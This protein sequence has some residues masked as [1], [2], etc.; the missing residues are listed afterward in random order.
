MFVRFVDNELFSW[1]LTI[2]DYISPYNNRHEHISDAIWLDSSSLFLFDFEVAEYQKESFMLIDIAENRIVN[3]VGFADTSQHGCDIYNSYLVDKFKRVFF[4][5]KL[6][7]KG[8]G[9]SSKLYFLNLAKTD[10][11]ENEEERSAIQLLFEESSEILFMV[12]NT[13]IE[14]G[15]HFGCISNCARKHSNF[16]S[17]E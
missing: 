10:D 3:R 5:T 6:H 14:G 17:D 16:I 12:F 7:M 4:A 8:N 11:P 2:N 15:S 13:E 1:T 9:N